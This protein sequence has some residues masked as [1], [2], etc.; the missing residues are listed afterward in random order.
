[1]EV[2]QEVRKRLI[3][4]V[5]ALAMVAVIGLVPMGAVGAATPTGSL[6]VVSDT[7]TQWSSD[8]ASWHSAQLCYYTP[9]A[10]ATISGA[11]WI[12]IEAQTNPEAE[13][14]DVPDGG[15][16]FQRQF[17]LPSDA[18]DLAGTISITADNAYYLY[19]NG[20]AVGGD[21]EMSKDGTDSHTYATVHT[22]DIGSYLT[23]GT[24]TIMVRALN[25]YDYG[26]ASSNPAG[27]VFKAVLNYEQPV[28]VNIDIKPGSYPN[29]VNLGDN[30]LLPVAILGSSTFDVST[31]NPSL[32]EIGGVG[33]AS[34]GS[35]KAP[36]LAYSYEDVN[37]DGFT[38]LVAFFD[39][40]T[41]Y[42]DGILTD[43]T[44]ALTLTASLYDGTPIEGMDSVNIVP[45][46]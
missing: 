20:N 34:R 26:S 3:G 42:S 41:L 35:A 27:L 19:V 24:N 40:Q 25:Y 18:F 4:V 37:G 5:L 16:Y 17:N 39:I 32:I 15:W 33:L 6:T 11:N 9:G 21:G 14:A 13:Y 2:T 30:G 8:N 23:A 43:A 31:I 29:S 1:M 45:P 36:K 10:W 38:D 22:W 28:T 46:S 7:N 44:T 12:W